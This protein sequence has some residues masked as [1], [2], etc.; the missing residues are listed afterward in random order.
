MN[1]RICQ[2]A[3]TREVT[4]AWVDVEASTP[5]NFAYMPGRT[6]LMCRA[7]H[8]T[9]ALG[10]A[11]TIGEKR[12]EWEPGLL[13]VNQYDG[14]IWRLDEREGTAWW[15]VNPPLPDHGQNRMRRE[16]KELRNERRWRLAED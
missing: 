15:I 3:I 1:C 4:E 2:Q 12:L 5:E 7:G 8:I 11:E 9:Q 16:E 10:E 6:F 14:R 13:I